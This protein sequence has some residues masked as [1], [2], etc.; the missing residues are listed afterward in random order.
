[1]IRYYIT[2][3][4]Q[5][6][7]IDSLLQSIARNIAQGVEYIQIREKD[8]PPR[9]LVDLVRK[10]VQIR[11]SSKILVNTRADIAI[12]CG[13]DGV[14]LPSDTPILNY[15][16]P[17]FL[18]GVSCHTMDDLREAQSAGASFAVYGPVFP[19]RSKLHTGPVTGLDQLRE[20]CHSVRIPVFALG[21]VT[22]EN[23]AACIQSGAAG[24]AAI[25]LFQSH[26]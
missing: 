18:T 25:T 9:D 20:A 7:G 14:H 23:A 8:L 17:G 6:G 12:A 1:M 4:K 19:P 26:P 10:A 22:S 11:A 16:I 21:G 15:G 3:R 24:I 13:A 2:D 5:L